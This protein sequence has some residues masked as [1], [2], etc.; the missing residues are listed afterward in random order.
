MRKFLRSLVF[1]IPFSAELRRS[2]KSDTEIIA[3]SCWPSVYYLCS[4]YGRFLTRHLLS[5]AP[6]PR[7]LWQGCVT[8]A[9]LQCCSQH[10]DSIN[11]RAILMEF[12]QGTLQQSWWT[13][14]ESRIMWF[15][16]PRTTSSSWMESGCI[17][18]EAF[19]LSTF[20]I[21]GLT[22]ITCVGVMDQYLLI[23]VT[24]CAASLK[25]S[26]EAPS[27]IIHVFSV[28]HASGAGTSPRL[29]ISLGGCGQSGPHG[30]GDAQ[31]QTCR[32]IRH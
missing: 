14:S 30:E 3:S 2:S 13:I 9:V 8:S 16:E 5:R 19:T 12:M 18:S 6:D 20:N 27:L 32:I 4:S 25:R 22:H 24:L 29:W 17:L 23:R 7:D 10:R 15:R 28:N 21:P 1:R 11:I 31:T 26:D